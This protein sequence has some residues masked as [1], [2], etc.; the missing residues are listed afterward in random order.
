MKSSFYRFCFVLLAVW[1]TLLTIATPAYASDPTLRRPANLTL[2]PL[3]PLTVGD[4]PSIVA[5]LTAEFGQPIRNQPII[6]FIDGKRKA[7]GRTDSRGIASIPL[8]FKFEA[9]TYRVLAVYPGIISIGVNRAT[10]ELAMVIEPVR[11]A[12]YTVPPV[13]GLLFKLN[14][15]T[16]ETDEN[17]IANIEVN[18]SGI[19]TLEVMP[20]DEATLPPNIRMEFARWNDN[21]FT[22]KRQVYFPRD[23]RLE[24]GFTVSY[25]VNQEFFD[26]TG[27]P[28]DPGRVDSI[29]VR[30]VGNTFT[31]DKA[32]PIWLP[33]NRLTRRI[34][35]RLE[36]EEILY[37][38][39]EILVD[40]ANVVNKS[41]QRFRIRP[42]DVWPVQVL[43]YSA[44]FSARDAMF[45]F[46]IGKGIELTYPDGHTEEFLFESENAEV[47]VPSL[48]RGS[49]SAR[50]I[51]AGGSA[52]PTPVHLSRD[53]DVELLMLSYLDI[54]LIIG[55]PL[56]IALAFF[57][58]GRPYWARVI[59][60]PSKYKELV[61]QSRSR[62]LSI[63]Q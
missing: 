29:T 14:D 58:I 54:A 10:A 51:G 42:D 41:E 50:I 53:Q 36:S 44:R 47:V 23:R 39:R 37:Y 60:H 52:P 20:I 59:R 12:I 48:A 28:V 34:G 6:I 56:I 24:V 15:Q 2:E 61:Y 43:L 13:P 1:L 63:K 57:F 27:E 35:E 7:E 5:H 26:T 32:G 17:G 38:F 55:I 49:Y 40:G 3:Q 19:F 22:Q 21:V 45:R 33:A 31:F 18:T 46:P 30:G 9:G 62:D 11:T 25:Q 4:H 16:Y 8:K